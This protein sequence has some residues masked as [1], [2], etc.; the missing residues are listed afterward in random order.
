[1]GSLAG[2]H[3]E[4]STRFKVQGPGLG[5]ETA[6]VEKWPNFTFASYRCEQGE[7]GNTHTRHTRPEA[8]AD[9][10][11]LP[12]Q[13]CALSPP[14]STCSGCDIVSIDHEELVQLR[15]SCA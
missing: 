13:V 12:E 11:T 7:E 3:R 4:H 9:M 15:L 2:H 1:M 5:P 14:I 10:T 8:Q 6:A